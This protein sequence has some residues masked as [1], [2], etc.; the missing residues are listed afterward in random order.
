[1]V[2]VNPTA[3]SGRGARWGRDVVQIL[4]NRGEQAR[5]VIGVDAA[6]AERRATEL[7][8][9]LKGSPI[10]GI[11]AVG[12]DGVVHM[13]INLAIAHDR[14]LGVIPAGTGNDFA[15]AAGVAATSPL[16]AL[17]QIL[18]TAASDG[19]TLVD[20]GQL[21]GGPAFGC[22]LSAG[23]DATVNAR[24]NR[25]GFPR[26]RARYPVAMLV[27]LPRFRA[28]NCRVVVDGVVHHHRAMLIAI[29][30]GPSYGAGMRICPSASVCDGILDV[31]VVDEIG[32]GQLLRMFPSVYAGTHIRHP[33]VHGYRGATVRLEFIDGATP[34]TFADGEPM[35]SAI[36]GRACDVSVRPGALRLLSP[37]LP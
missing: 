8:T 32:V 15:R 37:A 31:T 12:G 18:Q 21:A 25:I 9:S 3:G 14:A 5:V 13:A 6:D 4:K 17:N 24:A 22:V 16:N 35:S 23:F 30:N 20:V 28:L 33:K 29:G 2:L 19:E 27:E 1:V 11:L 10:A 7:L 34:P 26:G 36:V